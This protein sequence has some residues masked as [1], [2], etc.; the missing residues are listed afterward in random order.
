MEPSL[1][2]VHHQYKEKMLSSGGFLVKVYES[3][4]ILFLKEVNFLFYSTRKWIH[5]SYGLNFCGCQGRTC[6]LCLSFMICVV[7][8]DIQEILCTFLIHFCI[9]YSTLILSQ[10]KKQAVSRR[11]FVGATPFPKVLSCCSATRETREKN[12]NRDKSLSELSWRRVKRSCK[13]SFQDFLP[14]QEDFGRE[15]HFHEKSSLFIAIFQ[16]LIEEL[17]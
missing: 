13:N 11:D 15:G 9:S 2:T 10:K 12:F 8:V 6:H 14:T 4:R 16:P 5:D 17:F 7:F 3:E 1:I